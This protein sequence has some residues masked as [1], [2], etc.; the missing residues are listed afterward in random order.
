MMAWLLSLTPRKI[1]QAAP[2]ALTEHGHLLGTFAVGQIL[3][4]VSW[5]DAAVTAG[6]SRHSQARSRSSAPSPASSDQIAAAAQGYVD[7]KTFDQIAGEL[8]A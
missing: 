4:Q 7:D 1:A 8:R 2:A 3:K 6:L 5:S